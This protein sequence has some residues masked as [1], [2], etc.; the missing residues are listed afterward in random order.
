MP[1]IDVEHHRGSWYA[2]SIVL[3]YLTSMII[4]GSIAHVRAE[5]GGLS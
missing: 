4:K 2:F 3:L 1:I 5:L